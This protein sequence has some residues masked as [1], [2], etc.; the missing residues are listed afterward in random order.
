M[1]AVFTPYLQAK[2]AE[3]PNGVF[4][5]I[6]NHWAKSEIERLA[7]LQ[8]SN[9]FPDRSY[10]P[11]KNLSREEFVVFLTRMLG[12]SEKVKKPSFKD[13]PVKHWS[14][15]NIEAAVKEKI[16][17]VKDYPKG[18]DLRKPITRE[19]IALMTARALKLDP[20]RSYKFTFKDASKISLDKNMVAAAVKAGLVKGYPDKTFRP[21]ANSTRAEA[22]V[23]LIR[24]YDYA[25]MTENPNVPRP[26]SP[27]NEKG[28][29]KLNE[30]VVEL[31]EKI[32]NSLIY[33]SI[34]ETIF[35]FEGNDSKITSMKA[36][37][38]FVIPPS[39]K[40]PMGYAK[41]VKQVSKNGSQTTIMTT[42]PKI[43]EVVKELDIQKV[44]NISSANLIPLNLPEGVTLKKN[45]IPVKPG[46]YKSAESYNLDNFSLDLA[47]IKLNHKDI[48][49]SVNGEVLFDQPKLIV[50]F[51][52]DWFELEKFQAEFLAEMSVEVSASAKTMIS[53]EGSASGTW[54]QVFKG[55]SARGSI[56]VPE[57]MRK[58]KSTQPLEKEV[59]I[60]EFFLPIYGPVGATFEAYLVFNA[61]M[62]FG[63][64]VKVIKG[65]DI[66]FGVIKEDGKTK[67]IKK[68]EKKDPRVILTGQG[69]ID[70]Q[71]GVGF[72][73]K[74][75]LFKLEVGG[76]EAEAGAYG[77]IFGKA[78][79]GY[80]ETPDSID[81]SKLTGLF[82]YESSWGVFAE[83]EATLDAL[84]LFGM[85]NAEINLLNKR[86]AAGKQSS[87]CEAEMLNANPEEVILSPGEEKV[88]DLQHVEYD[89][90]TMNLTELET[91]KNNLEIKVLKGELKDVTLTPE[92]VTREK[93]DY[94]QL[95]ASA[96]KN[97][98][99]KQH[100]QV[101]L[102]YTNANGK[103]I[104]KEVDIYVTKLIG[105]EA[106]PAA[107]QIQQDNSDR[108]QVYALYDNPAG[109]ESL[110]QE[111]TDNPAVTYTSS[112]NLVRVNKGE[113]SVDP[114]ASPGTVATITIEYE[115][116]PTTV[117]VKILQKPIPPLSTDDI[118]TIILE[119][120]K[121]AAEAFRPEAEKAN[122]AP[123]ETAA[124][125]LD[126]VYTENYLNNYWQKV[127]NVNIKWFTD[128]HLLYP[129][130]EAVQVGTESS[131]RIIYQNTNQEIA[132]KVT[133]PL[134]P[135]E[136]DGSFTYQYKLIK[137]GTTWQLD[138]LTSE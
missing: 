88:I 5:D 16:I 71:A 25:L 87:N 39:E 124:A 46:M 24:F 137:I 47:G 106:R 108:F 3:D 57:W 121:K 55:G 96:N 90:E 117:P 67:K 110:R 49:I 100:I 76:L 19:E 21:K 93:R 38:I 135:H 61:D 118:K 17:Y 95:K 68:I 81:Q 74:L 62:T 77:Q 105:I 79:G 4:K 103:K 92:K 37:D 83:L 120:E 101:E 70:A 29:I 104:K 85:K 10:K 41:K 48:T 35:T 136:G 31:S 123:F 128:P 89:K 98:R 56:T 125:K 109:K 130:T 114:G 102:S 1:M 112:D 99:A 80:G 126:K 26:N 84:E 52:M 58:E 115:N 73:L 113:V 13:V 28:M 50:D 18:F 132:A 133:V 53:A 82:C 51:E 60:G 122:P 27:M 32:V 11:Q 42:D 34:D 119:A 66:D 15:P 72:G 75:A 20:E 94:L 54:S 97:A 127:Y 7:D 45:N 23:M 65:A 43:Q 40:Y 107:L 78:I 138:E 33:I 22:A 64:E 14:S 9:G 36:G 63:V 59:S 111:V 44:I 116:H 69:G 91:D 8:I 2:A 86:W 6:S 129:L 30:G 131:F 12:Y 134:R